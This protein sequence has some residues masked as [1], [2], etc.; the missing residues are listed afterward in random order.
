MT[1]DHFGAVFAPDQSIYRII[2]RMAFPIF[3]FLIVEG[4][5]HTSNVKKYL[6]RLG[7]FAV[8]SEGAFDLM[9]YRIQG[10]TNIWEQQNIFF[11]LFLGLCSLIVLDYAKDRWDTSG[12]TF[13][14]IELVT[15]CVAATI[16][17]F[18][19]TDY[20]A[21]GVF[22]IV[23]FYTYHNHWGQI[24]LCLLLITYLF[25]NGFS[26]VLSGTIPFQMWCVFSI[27]V[28]RLYNGEKGR[29]MKYFFYCYYPIHILILVG[30]SYLIGSC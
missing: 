14:F 17:Q 18:L 29:S 30:L 23:I 9:V 26:N 15:I 7:I 11:T 1:I 22:Y 21:M 19:Q 16:A 27:L 10:T 20:G 25:Y 24:T 28:L 2:G 13:L 3:A 6:L 8:L 12:M 5:S 4:F